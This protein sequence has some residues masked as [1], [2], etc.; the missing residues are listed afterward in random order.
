MAGWTQC[1]VRSLQA[2]SVHWTASVPHEA[3]TIHGMMTHSMYTISSDTGN[4][5]CMQILARA[6]DS[7]G[8]HGVIRVAK[9]KCAVSNEGPTS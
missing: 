9:A 6:P 4:G 3:T 5:V 8:T 2:I 7:L 1:S